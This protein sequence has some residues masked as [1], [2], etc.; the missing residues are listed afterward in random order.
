LTFSSQNIAKPLRN[1][2]IPLL[3][4]RGN[5]PNHGTALRRREKVKDKQGKEK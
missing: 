2:E 1:P 3:F 4:P 5:S